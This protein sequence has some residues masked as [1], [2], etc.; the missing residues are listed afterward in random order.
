MKKLIL[1][2]P[3]LLASS[4]AWGRQNGTPPPLN[5]RTND[6][7]VSNYP[8]QLKVPNGSLTDNN[9]GT[10]TYNL[11]SG[12]ILQVAI[13]SSS[14]FSSTTS[15]SFVDTNLS[16][17][18]TPS[19]TTSRTIIF[20]CG[21]ATLVDGVARNDVGSFNISNGAT[22]LCGTGGCNELQGGT[23]AVTIVMPVCLIVSELPGSV[24]PQTYKVRQKISNAGSSITFGDTNVTQY[25]IIVELGV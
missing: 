25:M 6:G 17:T 18:I 14:V 1:L 15:T 5:I 16:G 23:V 12:K 7:T 24:S 10:M 8:F 9:D 3:V 4:V 21:P 11:L 19:T 2:L 22:S 13:S 20:A